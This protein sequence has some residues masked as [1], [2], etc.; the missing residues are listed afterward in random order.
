MTACAA[1]IVDPVKAREVVLVDF[2]RKRIFW[3]CCAA[4]ESAWKWVSFWMAARFSSPH[5]YMYVV[6]PHHGVG[7]VCKRGLTNYLDSCVFC[8]FGIAT[9]CNAGGDTNTCA[10]ANAPTQVCCGV[11]RC[12]SVCCSVLRL[13][14][15]DLTFNTGLLSRICVTRHETYIYVS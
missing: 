8:V 7:F 10:H 4:S 6:K 2:L 15:R 9:H 3:W 14:T 5:W 11:L 1:N 13:H 12:V